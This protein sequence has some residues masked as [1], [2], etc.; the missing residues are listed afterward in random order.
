M[1][2]NDL[3]LPLT[4]QHGKS[5][6]MM[7]IIFIIDALLM[8]AVALYLKMV[9]NFAFYWILFV[10][11]LFVFPVALLVFR[12]L[13]VGTVTVDRFQ[14]KSDPAHLLGFPSSLPD[15]D[16]PM[17]EFSQISLTK[18]HAKHGAF[19]IPILDHGSDAKLSL[20]L[21]PAQKHDAAIQFARNLS[22]LINIP[23]KEI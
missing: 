7:R 19:Y 9:L 6:R 23:F 21:G 16:R 8:V 10:A 1:Q 3:T 15:L 11:I 17:T 20:P 4:I 14:V 2:T 5:W 18:I 13:K 22:S 12:A